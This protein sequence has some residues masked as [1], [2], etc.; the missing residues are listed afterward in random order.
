MSDEAYWA[1]LADT[2]VVAHFAFVSF[3]VI[4]LPVVWLGFF[5]RWRWVRNFWFRAIHLLMMGVVVFESV[6]GIVCP[7]TNW[8]SE[9]R[10]LAG[11]TGYHDKGFVEYW[12][13]RLMFFQLEPSTFT[14]IYIVF[15]TLLVGS[16][17]FVR[18][19][20]PGFWTR[21]NVQSP[22]GEDAP[23]DTE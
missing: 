11:Q 16:F 6:T 2:I 3:V 12:T 15:F 4:A 22:A 20:L 9:C 1:L 8:E 10:R 21:R 19:R 14:V 7:L 17:V 5:C 13:H 18:P 23:A